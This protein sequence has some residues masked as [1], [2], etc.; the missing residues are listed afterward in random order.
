MYQSVHSAKLHILS[1]YFVGQA[2]CLVLHKTPKGKVQVQ[3]FLKTFEEL[4]LCAEVC[5]TRC[6]TKG[7]PLPQVSL[8][9]GF[10][11]QFHSSL[12]RYCF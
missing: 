10:E 4:L 7:R 12:P 1:M 5:L 6:F 2:A 8:D 11:E 9:I 3:S